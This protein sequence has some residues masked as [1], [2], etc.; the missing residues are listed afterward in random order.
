MVD[1]SKWDNIWISSDDD[2]DCHPNIEKYAWRRLKQRMRSEK[3]EKV[4]EVELKDK[5]SSTNVNRSQPKKH[6]AETDPVEFLKKYRSKIE[7]Y[8]NLKSDVKADGFLMA[9]PQLACSLTEGFLI[10]QAVDRAVEN[11]DDPSIERV[12]RRCLQVHNLNVSAQAASI[13]A[14]KS[15]PLFFK[16]LKNEAK[17]KEYDIEF[18]K[19]LLEIKGRIETRRKER[20]EEAE[21]NQEEEVEADYEQAPLGPGGLDPTEVLQSL[22]EEIQQAFISQN[23][24]TLIKAL[25]K[26]SREE[27]NDIIKRCIDSG[28]WN[29][30]GGS[31]AEVEPADAEPAAKENPPE[32]VYDNSDLHE[33]D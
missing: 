6:L 19:Q 14:E 9:N 10:T 31:A 16:H 8:A 3:G 27:A 2:A 33:I 24:E 32:K 25:D 1:Y 7:K 20:L 23:K 21:Q 15:V 26:L 13:P 30:G 4:Q 29:P 12:A 28:L 5:W 11:P 18:E 17:K 22:P